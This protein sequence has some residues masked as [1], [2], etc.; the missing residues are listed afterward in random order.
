MSS[1]HE[2]D[3]SSLASAFIDL[4]LEAPSSRK[5]RAPV[6]KH[7]RNPTEKENQA[8]FYYIHYNKETRKPY[9]TSLLENI[10]KYI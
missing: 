6:W 5:L 2:L 7:I 10:K 1:S 3:S 9:Y 8:H 4:E